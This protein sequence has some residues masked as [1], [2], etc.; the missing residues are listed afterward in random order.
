MPLTISTSN[1]PATG[2][3][4]DS[5]AMIAQL[6]QRHGTPVPSGSTAVGITVPMIR[7]D[8]T[9]LQ[10][11]T[12]NHDTEFLFNT[13]TLR[14]TLSQEIHMSN[15]LS[16]CTREVWVEHERKHVRDNE[17]ILTRMDAALRADPQFAAILV[18]PTQWRPRSQ[19]QATQQTIQARVAEVFARLTRAAVQALDTPA[20]YAETE[21]QVRA[22]CNP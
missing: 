5:P 18:N 12:R 7:T 3:I 11:Q 9:G 22:R 6:V 1:T 19:F 4:L 15:D 14:L 10:Y 20:E 16:D 21:R 13:G 2:P 17:Q 8:Q